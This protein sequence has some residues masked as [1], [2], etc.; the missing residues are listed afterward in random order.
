MGVKKGPALAGGGQDGSSTAKEG[1]TVGPPQ[2]QGQG[3]GHDGTSG[4]SMMGSAQSQG[5]GG[6]QDGTPAVPGLVQ[7]T[8][9][10]LHSPKAREGDMMGHLQP[11]G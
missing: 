3:G 1:D 8:Q 10:D 2:P 4:R 9:P 11:Q 5:W 6:G 7:G